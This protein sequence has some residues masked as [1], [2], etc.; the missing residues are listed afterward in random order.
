ML[1]SLLVI[2]FCK[3]ADSD[4]DLKRLDLSGKG[5]FA[6]P[7]GIYPQVEDLDLS[8]NSIRE[9]DA[10]KIVEQFPALRQLN[11]SRNPISDLATF[12]IKLEYA[13]QQMSGG[14]VLLIAQDM[15]NPYSDD[16]D[17]DIEDSQWV[18]GD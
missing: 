4:Q 17:P 3:A 12:A 8:G 9:I 13:S 16:D 5:L 14:F 1:I 2:P 10:D 7:E 6:L 15:D 11:L 18:K